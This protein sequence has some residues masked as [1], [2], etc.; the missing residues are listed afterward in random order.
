LHEG[1]GLPVLEA[2]ASG[3]PVIC[4]RIEPLTEV[5]GDATF[6]VDPYD[7]EDIAHGIAALLKDTALRE[8]MI[9]KGLARAKKFTWEATALTTL[10][11]LNNRKV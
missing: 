11:F 5:A 2:M 10:D 1:F 8:K 4:S 3:V 9:E 7:H 6:F